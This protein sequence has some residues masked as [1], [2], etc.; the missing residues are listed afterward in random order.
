MCQKTSC[1]AIVVLGLIMG[2]ATPH[3]GTMFRPPTPPSGNAA[4]VIIHRTDSLRGVGPVDLVLGD[5]KLGPMHDREYLAL[6][7][8][9]GRYDLRARLRWLNLIPRSWNGLAFEARPG[10]TVHVRVWAQ[11]DELP[12][13]PTEPD[14]PGRAD[15]RAA[16]HIYLAPWPADEAAPELEKTHQ[17]RGD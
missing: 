16:I 17:A 9:P 13:S 6:L 3:K 11:Y 8:D 7:I 4:L 2:C 12:R 5:E 14:V 15:R 1:L 10:Q